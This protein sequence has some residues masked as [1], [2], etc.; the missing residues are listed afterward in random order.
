MMEKSNMATDGQ[1]LTFNLGNEIYAFEIRNVQEVL[2]YTRITKVPK[3]MDFLEGVINLRGGVVPVIDLRVKFG[4]EATQQTVETCIIILEVMVDRVPTILG[5]LVDSVKEV[6]D[7]NLDEIE[8]VP[9][10]GLELDNQ[11]IL[12]IGKH[13]N[14]FVIVLDINN[15][16]S[17]KELLSVRRAS[18]KK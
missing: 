17:D 1:S 13:D 16:F 10:I 18:E 12:G 11:F 6:I 14:D 3:S 7:L 15:L 8:P 4:M 9:K 5:V 2:D